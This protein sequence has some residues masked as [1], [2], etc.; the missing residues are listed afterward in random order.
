M[1][2]FEEGRTL[3]VPAWLLQ[4]FAE[5]PPA[6][7]KGDFFELEKKRLFPFFSSYQLYW[8]SLMMDR[9]QRQVVGQEDIESIELPCD[10]HAWKKNLGAGAGQ[11]LASLVSLLP[12]LGGVK[13]LAPLEREQSAALYLFKNEKWIKR[14]QKLLLQLQ[15]DSLGFE[16]ASGYINGPAE[17]TRILAGGSQLKK[18]LKAERPL[19][20]MRALWRDLEETEYRLLLHLLSA[21]R[22]RQEQEEKSRGQLILPVSSFALGRAQD[23]P[24][25]F[26]QK[27]A[28]LQR[29]AKK[30]HAHGYLRHSW[31]RLHYGAQAALANVL[32]TVWQIVLEQQLFLPQHP[33]VSAINS[34]FARSAWSE[35][36]HQHSWL[37]LFSAGLSEVQCKNFTSNVAKIISQQSP[38]GG[39]KG[40]FIVIDG[41]VLIDARFLFIEW[42]LRQQPR[43]Y[44]SLPASFAASGHGANLG[45]LGDSAEI[46]A[47]KYRLFVDKLSAAHESEAAY[48]LLTLMSTQSQQ[49]ASF[50]NQLEKLAQKYSNELT[51][52]EQ[53][54][55]PCE[56]SA[57]PAPA[58][59][60]K[61]R[62]LLEAKEE[63]HQ[64]LAKIK[65]TSQEKYH[66]LVTNYFNSLALPSQQIVLN[67]KKRLPPQQFE[68]HLMKRLARFIADN[69][70]Y[71]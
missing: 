9:V 64:G 57:T 69:P 62:L 19:S 28:I 52:Q 53:S 11:K 42:S 44:F 15:V 31:E 54:L 41:N 47:H 60:R 30:L 18:L 5:T 58:Q 65:A 13:F 68:Q 10:V 34:S 50:K 14:D 40:E 2:S 67:M 49:S 1:Q 63:K 20:L 26:A 46:L 16:L 17:L 27:I 23:V 66:S 39:N 38:P 48:S 3:T 32:E 24:L 71:Q 12:Q 21:E 37:S 33:L 61:V 35:I 55:P 25:S 29:F 8:L 4:A 6:A 22:E 51:S 56:V 36:P 7:A 59:G 45:N 70:D 43:H